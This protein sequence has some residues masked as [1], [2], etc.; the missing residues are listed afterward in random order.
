MDR[1]VI[2]DGN[3]ILHRAY[4]ALPPLTNKEG[5]PTN[6]VYGFASMILKI[7]SDLKPK[8]LAV[9]F[10]R[11]APTFR[12]KLYTEYQATRPKMEENLSSQ[13]EL[14]HNL[15]T[16]LGIPI[17][18]MDGY[19][20]DDIIGSLA[21]QAKNLNIKYQIL[22]IKNTNQKSKINQ[23]KEN[24]ETIIVTGDRDMLQLVDNNIKVYMLVK[25]LSEAKLYG[26]TE[27]KEKFGLVPSQITDLKA[28]IGDPSDNYPG[29]SGIGPK[30]AQY[31]LENYQN[32]ENLYKSI[33][34]R[35]F[36]V[37][38]PNKVVNAL[39]NDY[40]NAKL[41]KRL[42]TIVCDAPVTFDAEKAKWH[43]DKKRIVQVFLDFGFESLAKRVEGNKEKP[44]KKEK[45]KEDN[46]QL[47]LF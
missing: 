24:I 11:P 21:F 17:Y 33:K 42:A 10:D 29:V 13:V 7:F 27:V 19:E 31:L 37:K 41:S 20:A 18:E 22:N 30:T 32:L 8:Y 25:G 40:E 35:N 23:D 15:V 43:E 47:G 38:I 16:A 2:I 34:E 9:T 12:K 36:P 14:V 45:K 1:L 28:L 3:A 46:N 6:A 4:H 26:V 5:K 44:E 39:V